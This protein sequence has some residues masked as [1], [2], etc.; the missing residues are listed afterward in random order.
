MPQSLLQVNGGLQQGPPVPGSDVRQLRQLLLTLL[1]PLQLPQMRWLLTRFC[2]HSWRHGPPPALLP[3]VPSH[4]LQK[5][6]CQAN[7]GHPL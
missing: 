7:C 6:L 3:R 5:G 2:C 1:V 4:Q